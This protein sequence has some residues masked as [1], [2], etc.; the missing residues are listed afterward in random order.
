MRQCHCSH[1][2]MGI[3]I[4]CWAGH[5]HVCKMFFQV[6]FLSSSVHHLEVVLGNLLLHLSVLVCCL[7]PG[8]GISVKVQDGLLVYDPMLIPRHLRFS[9]YSGAVITE[10]LM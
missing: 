3:G 6:L 9:L 5:F 1:K 7:D 2:G 4:H 8:H 10:G